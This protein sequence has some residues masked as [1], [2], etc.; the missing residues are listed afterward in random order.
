M[1]FSGGI[2]LLAASVAAWLL[3]P[4]PPVSALTLLHQ[5]EEQE[6][7]GNTE[8]AERLAAEALEAAPAL[9]EAALLAIRC[10]EARQDY[11]AA[12][13]HVKAAAPP[14]DG[15]GGAS[16]AQLHLLAG[17]LLHHRL[18]R[19]SEAEAAYRNVLAIVEDHP[20]AN[21]AL[22]RLLATCNRRREAVPL[23]LRLI[24]MGEETDLLILLARENA[25]QHS[26]DLLAKA[27]TAAPDD[28]C[29]LLG[30][31][32]YAAEDQRIDEA[33]RL[34][35]QAS[36]MQ[37][38]LPAA[39]AALGQQL[40]LAGRFKELRR[41]SGT[42]SPEA[43]QFPET[44]LARAALAEH[45]GQAEGAIRCRW[46][47]VRR[48]PES[49]Q[50]TY[51]LA[52]RLA[53]AGDSASA[54]VF[55]RRTQ[56]LQELETAIN[57]SLLSGHQAGL[58]ELLGLVRQ[59]RA[60]GRMWEAFAWV[61]VA[62]Q[63]G[64]DEN[65]VRTLHR[66]LA[67]A[68]QN[69]PLEQ[70]A[71]AANPGLTVDLSR[72][73]L[74][75]GWE[76]AGTGA[77]SA[78][79]S[80]GHAEEP[81]PSG[82][83]PTAL[84]FRNDAEAAG[85]RFRYFNGT[86]GEMNRRM[87]EFT[88]GGAGVL[89]ADLD[90]FPDVYWSQGRDVPP[91][92]G[93]AETDR[94]RT[95][96]MSDRVFRNVD[97]VRF[98]DVSGLAGLRATGFGQ[99]V[100]VGDV[101]ADGFPD[102]YVAGTGINALWMNN[103]DGTFRETGQAAGLLDR[104]WTTSCLIADVDGDGLPDVYDVNYV[105]GDDVFERVCRQADGSAALCM[106]FDFE[107]AA[108]QLW[109]NAGDGRF[110]VAPAEL[111]AP[112]GGKGLGIA[113]WDADGSGRLSL[114]ITNDTTPNFFLVPE[115]LPNGARGWTER[116]IPAGVA[117]NADGK[118]EGC[119]GIALGDVD[120]DGHLDIHVTNFL[121]ESNTL[122][123]HQAGGFYDDRTKLTGLAQP[124]LNVLGFGTQFLDADLDGR[125]E[126][127]VANGHVDDLRATGRPWRMRPQLFRL[128][129]SR[130]AE[131]PAD[132][133]GPYFAQEWL[134]RSVARL[135]WNRDGLDDLVVGQL[136]DSSAL[137]TNTTAATGRFLSLRLTG[138][139]SARDA[140]GTTVEVHTG[141][142]TIVRQLTAG[143]GYQASNERRLVIGVGAADRVDSVK[144]RWPSG[145][146]QQFEEVAVPAEIWLV[147]GGDWLPAAPRPHSGSSMA[148]S[149]ADVTP[150]VA[151]SG[152]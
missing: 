25:V 47:A 79:T 85:M 107:A 86:S 127:F 7:A 3:W 78:L 91:Q 109:L 56:Q 80:T 108:D 96:E 144:I 119:M 66:E 38:R 24:R 116:G 147:E 140:V 104:Q 41:W 77:G 61:Q 16:A 145:R 58:N 23:I 8:A 1:P 18:Y 35:N 14:A 111:A 93:E 70:T 4:A 62:A 89:D 110:V 118:A 90:G 92:V 48:G 20:E 83:E 115:E 46:E 129:G 45:L 106:P 148:G 94:G 137:L 152:R 9:T 132:S 11:A 143:D 105:R 123:L 102:V 69:L 64:P 34:L 76:S 12:L 5:A 139:E 17:R 120:D 32:W 128:E 39:V 88:G 29:P 101:D 65:E 26:P 133:I 44:W 59:L 126:L 72:F 103:G 13:N 95:D 57:R 2:A 60:A 82:M 54:A 130:F 67:G 30:L 124:T 68:V 98:E 31:A 150:G 52:H 49:R 74:P 113:A 42:V 43:E 36:A 97:G 63:I 81:P 149:P 117:L 33:I 40:A 121:A 28:P 134:S 151:R 21:D 131:V 84:T 142:R 73:E 22:A 51:Q 75:E 37:R 146:T 141:G 6:R 15:S 135:D 19:L 10:A 87:F 55:E 71:A 100:A 99:G 136:D 50:A 114:L 112:A 53:Q 125:L 122:Y 27:H 138:V